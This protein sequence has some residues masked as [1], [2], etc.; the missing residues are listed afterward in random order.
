[1]GNRLRADLRSILDALLNGCGIL[2]YLGGPTNLS[3][4]KKARLPLDPFKLIFELLRPAGIVW[5]LWAVLSLSLIGFVARYGYNVPYYDEWNLIPLLDGSKH[6]NVAHWL[7]EQH[8]TGT[9][10][11]F[12]SSF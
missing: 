11:L 9:G 1:M 3:A 6:V 7:W 5:S 8:N 10:S 2:R 4:S 12:P